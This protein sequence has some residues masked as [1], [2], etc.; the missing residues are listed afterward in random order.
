MRILLVEDDAM[1]GQALVDQLNSNNFATDWFRNGEDAQYAPL[2]VEYDCILL[3][4]GLPKIDGVS[5]L[6]KWRHEKVKT[7]IIILTARDAL[8][9]RVNGLD[10]GADDYI[11]K[12]FEF[13]ELK[14]RIRAVTRRCGSNV[15]S[16]LTNGLITLD[17]ISHEVTLKEDGIDKK[18]L[19]TAREFSLLEALMLRP[20]AVL[21]RE[22][23]EQKIYSFDEEI[24]SNAVEYIIHTLRKKIGSH[25]IKNVRG[26]GWKVAKEA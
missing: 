23:L 8:D 17:P 24:E 11:V 3:D 6:I 18:V 2:D 19:L 9:D 5:L 7:P 4:L 26:V 10:R 12:P 1:I 13:S 14:A 25:C 15:Q 20:G 22:V 16:I 21:S